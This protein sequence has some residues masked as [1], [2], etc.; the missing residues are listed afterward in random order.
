MFFF[1]LFVVSTM[2][3]VGVEACGWI[4]AVQYSGMFLLFGNFAI[5]VGT[6]QKKRHSQSPT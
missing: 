6:V 3:E 5:F 2:F 4:G 1:C